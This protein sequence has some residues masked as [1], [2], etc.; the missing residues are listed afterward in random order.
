M[1][2]YDDPLGGRL[3]YNDDD[4]DGQVQIVQDSAK[5][6]GYHTG[7]VEGLL[8][9]SRCL[10]VSVGSA[11]FVLIQH[12]A[13]VQ[14]H[15]QSDIDTR[16]QSRNI[17]WAAAAMAAMLLISGVQSCSTALQHTLCVACSSDELCRQMLPSLHL[18]ML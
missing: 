3:K 18:P 1:S 16:V 13:M 9:R 2:P 15:E 14:D 6:V 17:R 4:Q 5:T 7:S 12:C 11:H 10:M 8:Y